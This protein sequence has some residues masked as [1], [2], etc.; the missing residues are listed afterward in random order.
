MGYYA[1]SDTKVSFSSMAYSFDRTAVETV[2]IRF[3]F[4]TPLSLSDVS[5]NAGTFSTDNIAA[6]GLFSFYLYQKPTFTLTGAESAD[7]EPTDTTDPDPEPTDTADPDPEP[8]DTTDPDPEPTDTTDPEPDPEPEPSFD[9]SQMGGLALTISGA[10]R[11]LQLEI[12]LFG[13]TF[14]LWQLLLFDV[15]AS[16]IIWFVWRFLL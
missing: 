13:F 4:D 6:Y 9:A 11:L 16:L 5:M 10:V 7:P 8:T 1:D 2:G 3:Y 12:T 14:S 15:A